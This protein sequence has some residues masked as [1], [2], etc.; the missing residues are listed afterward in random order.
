MKYLYHLI[1][2][3]PLSCLL[4]VVIWYLCFFAPP[5]TKLNEVDY[6]DKWTH[7]VMYL[8]TCSVIWIEYLKRHT[9]V[10][11]T[12]AILLAWLAPIL[13][14]GLIELLQ[15]HCTN[16]RRSGEWLDVA[17]NSIGVT[18]ALVIGILVARYHGKA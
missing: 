10:E 15:A 4:I 11:W 16:G 1:I 13:M 17:A 12:K 3:Y 2:K 5:E 9:K 6:I 18:L 14:S 8:G 7:I